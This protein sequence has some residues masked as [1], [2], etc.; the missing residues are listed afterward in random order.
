[1]KNKILLFFF[2]AMALLMLPLNFIFTP[3]L[4]FGVPINESFG[5]FISGGAGEFSANAVNMVN[6]GNCWLTLG[7]MFWVWVIR[8]A[9]YTGLISRAVLEHNVRWLIQTVLNKH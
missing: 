7:G 1:M 5:I 9:A 8:L 4:F 2:I 3:M 6:A